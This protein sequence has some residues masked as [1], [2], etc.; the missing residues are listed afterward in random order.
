MSLKNMP[1]PLARV[2]SLS[3]VAWEDLIGDS[4]GGDFYSSGIH[5][6]ASLILLRLPKLLCHYYAFS[7]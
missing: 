4:A 7:K 6:M 1:Q 2:D 5:L 3:S